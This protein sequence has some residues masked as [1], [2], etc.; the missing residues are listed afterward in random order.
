M[1]VV[2]RA[3]RAYTASYHGI[4]R[5]E[6][7]SAVRITTSIVIERPIREVFACASNPCGWTE[8]IAGAVT[9]EQTWSGQLDVGTTFLQEAS[10]A[11]SWD[12]VSW[13]VTEYEPPRVFACRW[14]G[15]TCG[16]VRLRCE[17]LGG[18]TRMTVSSEEAVGLFTGGPEVERAI[19]AQMEHDLATL[20]RYPRL[21]IDPMLP[22]RSGGCVGRQRRH[23]PWTRTAL[24]I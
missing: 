8:W 22:A 3:C 11:S 21:P 1:C 7:S 4:P 6:E 14:G 9:V 24:T 5:I 17:A 19:R 15:A 12:D 16:A 20:K 13:E 2:E 10:L 18:T 23:P